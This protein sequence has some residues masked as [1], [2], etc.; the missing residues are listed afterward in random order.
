MKTPNEL[1]EIGQFQDEVRDLVIRMTGAPSQAIDG[2]GSDAGWQEFTLAEISQGIA[3]V[4]DQLRAELE[5]VQKQAAAM[6]EALEY[7][8]AW[9]LRLN[10]ILG[11]KATSGSWDK[12]DTALSSDA[13][14][15]YISREKV[16]AEVERDYISREKASPLIDTLRAYLAMPSTDGNPERQNLRAIL[17]GLLTGYE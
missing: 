5:R 6:R 3:F 10:E 8:K 12:I 17:L 14:R 11:Y 9:G 13:G 15:D 16:M 7:F 1:D 2:K 4:Q